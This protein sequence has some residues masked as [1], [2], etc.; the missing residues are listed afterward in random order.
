MTKGG[1]LNSTM[2]LVYQVYINA[3]EKTD[4]MGYASALALLV[5]LLLIV[6]SLIQMKL[7]KWNR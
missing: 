2:T 1:P 5:F 6:F 3:F 7:L 4:T